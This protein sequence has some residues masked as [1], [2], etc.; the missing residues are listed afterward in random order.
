MGKF[1]RQGDTDASVLDGRGIDRHDVGAT[2]HECSFE[3][4]DRRI[5]SMPGHDQDHGAISFIDR[6]AGCRGRVPPAHAPAAHG[7]PTIWSASSHPVAVIALGVEDA[8][9]D[10]VEAFDLA[11]LEVAEA[12][13]R[14]RLSAQSARSWIF[15]SHRGSS[16]PSTRRRDTACDIAW[17][18]RPSRSTVQSCVGACRC[19]CRASSP[20]RRRSRSWRPSPKRPVGTACSCGTTCGTAP[21]CRSLIRSS[22]WPRSR[23]D[24]PRSHRHDGGRAAAASNTAGRAGRH[25][26]R[27]VVRRP[28][29]PR[30]RPGGRQLRRVLDLR[31]A[32]S[33]RSRSRSSTRRRDRCTPADARRTAGARRRRPH[34]HGPGVQ[35]PRLPIWIAGRTGRS[36]GPRRVE[37]HGLEGLALVD[38]DVWSPRPRRRRSRSRRAASGTS[39]SSSSAGPIRTPTRSLPPARRGACPRSS[40]E[41][42]WP[43]RWTSPARRHPEAR[44]GRA[45]RRFVGAGGGGRA[46]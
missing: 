27:S 24:E 3:G 35:Q 31:R 23:R 39:T 5:F 28:H 8:A 33:G 7:Q 4:D 9:S 38:A 41:P 15:P 13:H 17:N 14:A 21:H 36:A 16:S 10:D 2:A 18:G 11:V 42:R 29:G 45:T 26:P 1:E 37:R 25:Q 43:R 40:R 6:A 34:D 30:P 12:E 32:G 19:R 22:P 44:G 46:S 20:T